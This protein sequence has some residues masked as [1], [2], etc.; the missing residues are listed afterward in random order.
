[1]AFTS[2]GIIMKFINRKKI[3]FCVF[4]LLCGAV[5]ADAVTDCFKQIESRGSGDYHAQNDINM[6]GRYQMSVAQMMALGFC[7]NIPGYWTNNR[8]RNEAAGIDEDYQHWEDCQWTDKAK[9]LGVDSKDDFLNNV[10][11]IQDSMIVDQMA[12]IERTYAN[13]NYSQYVGTVDRNTG[14]VITKE[15]IMYM[16]HNA[17]PGGASDYLSGRNNDAG[18]ARDAKKMSDCMGG[19]TP[20]NPSQ[21]ICV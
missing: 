17:G 15:S 2:M 3:F 11:G 18:I 7:K 9:N 10:G 5:L 12:Y 8:K 13:G 4:M 6:L 16:I 19:T 21:S 20:S 1:M 14:E